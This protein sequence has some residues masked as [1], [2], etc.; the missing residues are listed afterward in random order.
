MTEE[1]SKIKWD[2]AGIVALIALIIGGFVKFSDL[3]KIQATHEAKIDANTI[4]I[5]E[6]KKDFEREIDIQNAASIRFQEQ[7]TQQL[8]KIQDRVDKIHT[9]IKDE[10]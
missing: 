6:I 5:V 7:T 9:L 4:A 2:L 10:Q 8:T 1:K 3:T